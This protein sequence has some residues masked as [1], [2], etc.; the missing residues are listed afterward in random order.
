MPITDMVSWNKWVR[1]NT[2]AYGSA[3]IA[4][5]RE[6]M[7]IL[8]ESGPIDPHK[9]ISDAD[10]KAKTGGITGFMAGCVAGMISKCHSRGEEFRRLWNKEYQLENEGDKAN[11][12]GTILNP[13][14]LNLEAKE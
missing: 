10:D 2:D 4:V 11:E 12:K 3:C 8:D 1:N 13:A 6:A 14:L 5:A 9:L 7:E